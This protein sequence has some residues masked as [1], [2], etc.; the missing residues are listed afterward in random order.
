MRYIITN[1][2]KFPDYD[3]TIG[4]KLTRHITQLKIPNRQIIST[5]IILPQPH[6]LATQ[7]V[8]EMVARGEW[9]LA[10]S[11]QPYLGIVQEV[12]KWSRL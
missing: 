2:H 4:V 11:R 3:T 6:Y 9:V 10:Q 1:L 5:A 7:D 8:L 12:C